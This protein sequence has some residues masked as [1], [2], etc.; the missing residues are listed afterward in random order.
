MPRKELSKQDLAFWKAYIEILDERVRLVDHWDDRT[1]TW[2]PRIVRKLLW[3]SGVPDTMG[4]RGLAYDWLML[5][6]ARFTEQ[7]ST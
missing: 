6:C 5:H 3:Y 2:H 4:N 7:V 1:V